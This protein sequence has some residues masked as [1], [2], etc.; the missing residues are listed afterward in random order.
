M[1]FLEARRFARSLGLSGQRQWRVYCKDGLPNLPRMPDGMPSSP[2]YMYKNQG[3]AGYPDWLGKNAGGKLGAPPRNLEEARSYSR[4]LGLSSISQWIK[5]C[6]AVDDGIQRKPT[7][8]PRNPHVKYAALGWVSWSDWLGADIPT[9]RPS[10]TKRTSRFLPFDD[11]RAFVRALGIMSST[12]WNEYTHDRLAGRGSKPDN[13]PKS[14]KSAYPN[15][16][17]GWGDWLGH[18]RPAPFESNFLPYEDAREFARQHRLKNAVAWRGWVSTHRNE[19][20]NV[21]V[22]ARKYYLTKGWISW[23]DF[24]QPPK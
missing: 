21:P 2:E 8:I 24:L 17:K 16:W 19:A 5:F 22:D 3:W 9:R 10:A 4:A 11:A 6:R 23:E 1:D 12:D 14:P 15:E 20:P 13:I 7:D 18:D